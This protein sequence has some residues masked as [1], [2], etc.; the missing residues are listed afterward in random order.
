MNKILVISPEK[1]V[2]H[3]A[4]F[5]KKK[6]QILIKLLKLK[7][8]GVEVYLVGDELMKKNVLAFPVPKNFPHPDMKVNFLGEIY[9]NPEYIKRHNENLVYLLTHGFLH[10]LGYGHKKK[11]YRIKMENKQQALLQRLAI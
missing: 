10:L 5:I 8:I 9:L 11:N 4:P 6:A 1:E 2:D 7:N 3:L